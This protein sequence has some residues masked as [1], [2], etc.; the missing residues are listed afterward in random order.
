MCQGRGAQDYYKENDGC[1]KRLSEYIEKWKKYQVQIRQRHVFLTQS[2]GR[3]KNLHTQVVSDPTLEL[4]G[5]RSDMGY[6]KENR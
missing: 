4:M 5:G 1:P 2:P 6:Q 3:D